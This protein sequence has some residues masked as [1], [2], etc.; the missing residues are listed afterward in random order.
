MDMVTLYWIALLAFFALCTYVIGRMQRGEP[1]FLDAFDRLIHT[2]FQYNREMDGTLYMGILA[3]LIWKFS[4][5]GNKEG[6]EQNLMPL[7]VAFIGLGSFLWGKKIGEEQAMA[8][9][10]SVPKH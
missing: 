7:A 9:G 3:I 10:N 6:N 4:T 5:D 2:L 8:N 1:N